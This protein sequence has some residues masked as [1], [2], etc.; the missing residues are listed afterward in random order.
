MLDLL[1][2]A[3][4]ARVVNTVSETHSGRLDFGNLQG[5]RRYSFFSAYAGSKL[6]N[7]LFTYELARRL[8]GT[9][10]T[11]NCFTPGPT[12]SDFGRGMGGVI[13][14]MGGLMRLIGRPAE[15]SAR[16]AVYLATSP[17]M[18]GTGQYLFHGKSAR[19]KPI[20][21]D[22]TV[23][24]QLWSVSESLTGAGEQSAM[25]AIK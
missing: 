16:T 19:S 24:A 13:G 6:A 3:P 12:A 14:I 7:I 22:A 10:V 2:A 23:A 9:A 5:E 21:Y 20:T 25:E 4:A 17:E 11:A 15:E 18:R 1:V 8:E